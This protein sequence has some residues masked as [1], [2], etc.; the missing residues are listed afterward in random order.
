MPF[1]FNQLLSFFPILCFLLLEEIQILGD[2]FEE[3]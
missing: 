3:E 1:Y 2:F